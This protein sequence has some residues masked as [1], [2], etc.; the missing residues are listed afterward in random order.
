MS[1]VAQFFQTWGAMIT[2]IALVVTL[3][4]I[5]IYTCETKKLRKATFKQTELSLTPWIILEYKIKSLRLKNI[6]HSPALNIRIEPIEV[7]D[8]SDNVIFI[9]KFQTQY[10]LESQ[11]AAPLGLHLD[12][13][14]ENFELMKQAYGNTLDFPY[15]PDEMKVADYPSIK[16]YYKNLENEPFITKVQVKLKEKRLEILETGKVKRNKKGY[17][18]EAFRT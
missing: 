15:F 7:R 3:V 8:A 11:D 6:G 14:T 9:I 1:C 12:F 4:V 5:I 17:I 18:L 2:T 16:I 13:K 10:V